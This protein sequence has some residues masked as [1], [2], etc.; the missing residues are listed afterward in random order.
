ML[1]TTGL[2]ILTPNGFEPFSGIS[3]NGVQPTIKILFDDGTYI[4]ATTTHRLFLDGREIEVR[5]LSKG[6]WLD[7]EDSKQIVDIIEWEDLPVYDILNVPSHTFYC[8]GVLSHNCEFI[9]S[10]PLLFDTMV[11]AYL[12]TQ[13]ENTTP[14]GKMDDIVFYSPPKPRGTYLVGMDPATGT[15]EDFTTI[16]VYEFPSLLQVAEWRSNTMSSAKSYQVLKKLLTV[17]DKVNAT[18]FFSVENNG[19]GEGIIAMYEFDEFPPRLAEFVSDDG[20]TKVGMTTTGKSKMVACLDMKEMIEKGLMVVKSNILIQEMK[21]Y[22]RKGHAY[23]AKSGGTDDLI[24]ATLIV[25]RLIKHMATYDQ[26]A[27]DRLYSSGYSR[28]GTLRIDEYDDNEEGDT[29]VF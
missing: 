21:Q 4:I 14:Y 8:N 22:V 16:L 3:H 11:L 27:F 2:K 17:F 26:V 23:A 5:E 19:V 28:E 6:M 1:N 29:I 10:D 9:S 13:V 15:G 18:V 20:A 7:G 24:S 12:T 25:I